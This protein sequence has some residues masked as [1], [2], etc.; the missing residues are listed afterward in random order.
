MD[1]DLPERLLPARDILSRSLVLHPQDLAPAMPSGLA[2]DL[3]ARF[4]APPIHDTTPASP[5]LMERLRNWMA[6]PG[7]GVAAAAVVVVGV[8][9]PMI[10]A[11]DE[12][13]R[14]TDKQVAMPTDMVKIAFVGQ[15]PRLE[16]ALKSSGHFEPLAFENDA[17][18][19]P[20]PKVVIDFNTGTVSSVNRE[21]ATVYTSPLP[22]NIK[23]APTI[24][25]DA[26]SRIGGK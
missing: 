10:W 13:F 17:D 16:M 14:G 23:D 24:V 8:A 11:P 2:E 6:S 25:S 22:A 5:G 3:A 21:G 1:P 18:S 4:A 7:F 12:M 20:A 9:V 26:I 15:N 19:V